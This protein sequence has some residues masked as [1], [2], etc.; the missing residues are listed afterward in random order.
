MDGS[1]TFLIALSGYY[2]QL[3]LFV[4]YCVEMKKEGI[5]N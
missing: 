5:P 3:T 1:I 4:C 2:H